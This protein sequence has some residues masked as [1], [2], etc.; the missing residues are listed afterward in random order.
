M[1]EMPEPFPEIR[2][3]LLRA[4]QYPVCFVYDCDRVTKAT[5]GARLNEIVIAGLSLVI[6]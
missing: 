2:P 5:P 1:P 6:Y 4:K 3:E